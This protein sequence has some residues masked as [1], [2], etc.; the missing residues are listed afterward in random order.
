MEN[1][2]NRIIAVGRLD[3]EL[4]LSHEGAFRGRWIACR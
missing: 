3:G 1:P 4:E 2:N